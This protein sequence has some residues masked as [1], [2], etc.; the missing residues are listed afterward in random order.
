MYEYV[1]YILLTII[2]MIFLS[3]IYNKFTK[4]S[5]ETSIFPSINIMNVIPNFGSASGAS[6]TSSDNDY[7]GG[8]A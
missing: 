7:I 6:A 5:G 8:S 3:L 1:I 2:F 4:N